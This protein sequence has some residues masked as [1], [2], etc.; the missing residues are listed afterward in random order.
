M[1]KLFSKI[2]KNP[3]WLVLEFQTDGICVVHLTMSDKAQVQLAMFYPLAQSDI[4]TLLS[5]INKGLRLNRYD[6]SY[7][8]SPHDY[9]ISSVETPNVP[10][11]EL[12][13]AVRW[14]LK[15]MLD[16]HIDDATIDVLGIPVDKNAA[17]RKAMMYVIS[18]R[19]QLIAQRQ[20]SFDD[21]Q[22]PVTVI[23]IPE[24][25]QRNIANLIAP[26]ERGI[27]LLSVNQAGSLLTI[28]YN[29]ELYLSR[30]LDTN[31]LQLDNT[32]NEQAQQLFEKITLELQRTFDHVDRQYN[33]IN[34]S[35]LMVMPC[36]PELTELTAYL[37]ANLYIPAESLDLS[38]L[39]D[40]TLSPDLQQPAQQLRFQACLG[41]ALRHEE[42][43]L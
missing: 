29:N 38:T 33:F 42:K 14:L 36:L 13:T 34:L 15:D 21:A 19:N 18:A 4:A 10:Q 3:G 27:A 39:F 8:L 28:S 12:K 11:E 41:A 2:K 20:A 32:K 40:F 35:K 1:M 7:L 31:L 24:L 6:C 25:A 5:R 22:I 43:T 16:Y 23:D 9:Q 37:A 30:R 26:A 17:T